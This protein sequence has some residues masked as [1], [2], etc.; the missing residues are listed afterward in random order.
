MVTA[1]P[2]TVDDMPQLSPNS[3]QQTSH[4][5]SDNKAV[6]HPDTLPQGKAPQGKEWAGSLQLTPGKV[7][8]W[9]WRYTRTTQPGSPSPQLQ[10]DVI[11][12]DSKDDSQAI[13]SLFTMWPYINATVGSKSP[14]NP[15]GKTQIEDLWTGTSHTSS[16]PPVTTEPEH[17]F[18]LQ[19]ELQP[20]SFQ[21]VYAILKQEKLRKRLMQKLEPS[22]PDPRVKHIAYSVEP[23]TTT[24]RPGLPTT[25]PSP[26]TNHSNSSFPSTPSIPPVSPDPLPSPEG[27]QLNQS[28]QP[29]TAGGLPSSL[30]RTQPNPA[31]GGLVTDLTFWEIGNRNVPL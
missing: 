7:T 1:V 2:S 10:I 31:D 25:P 20:L 17:K 12:A 5:V 13:P 30:A 26:S 23:P 18:L 4:L 15:N 8:P 28:G 9:Y 14:R 11:P 16:I 29:Q 22:T 19:E 24:P 21:K 3:I 27:P 6:R